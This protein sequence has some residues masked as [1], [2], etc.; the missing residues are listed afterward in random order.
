MR[1]AGGHTYSY[2][3]STWAIEVVNPAL[4]RDMSFV[5]CVRQCQHK[6]STQTVITIS[7]NTNCYQ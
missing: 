7:G 1:A 2:V 6:Q 3:Q 5:M 4:H